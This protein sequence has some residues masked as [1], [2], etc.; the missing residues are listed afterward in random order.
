M[1]ADFMAYNTDFTKIMICTNQSGSGAHLNLTI[2]IH[3]TYLIQPIGQLLQ[4]LMYEILKHK[5]SHHP[6]ICV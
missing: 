4:I 6:K 2:M 5:Q 3:Q 1:S